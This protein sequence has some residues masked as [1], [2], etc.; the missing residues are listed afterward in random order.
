MVN[1]CG[2]CEQAVTPSTPYIKCSGSCARSIHV[3][4]SG[5]RENEVAYILHKKTPWVCVSCESSRG[6]SV[7]SPGGAD[8]LSVEVLSNLLDQKLSALKTEMFAMFTARFDVI[9]DKVH[10]L[11]RENAQLRADVVALRASADDDFGNVVAELEERRLRESNVLNFSI[12]ESSAVDVQRRINDDISAVNNIFQT[13]EISVVPR[14]VVRLGKRSPN[15]I[16]PL[17]VVLG[18]KTEA[19]TVLKSNAKVT[20][21]RMHFRSDKTPF[22]MAYF[23]KKKAELIKRTEDGATGLSIKYR[24]GVP[25]ISS[26]GVKRDTNSSKN[27]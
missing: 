14:K 16:R 9:E 20:D 21:R 27:F 26:D 10:K 24:R 1:K 25:Y 15:K 11:E 22:E 2:N 4:C 12:P 6:E 8:L 7:D 18:N 3:K 17:K 23:K 19:Q 5:L 13:L